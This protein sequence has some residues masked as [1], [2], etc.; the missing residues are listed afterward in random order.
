MRKKLLKNLCVFKKKNY[1]IYDYSI[2]FCLKNWDFFFFSKKRD[3]GLKFQ[4]LRKNLK[5]VSTIVVIIQNRDDLL[6]SDEET[7][8][9]IDEDSQKGQILKLGQNLLKSKSKQ[10]IE[11]TV[12]TIDSPTKTVIVSQ[13]TA[14]TTTIKT[15]SSNQQHLEKF[16]F[17]KKDKAYLSRLSSYV[18]KTLNLGS[19]FKPVKAETKVTNKMVFSRLTQAPPNEEIILKDEVRVESD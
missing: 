7:N 5:I 1:L 2:F 19:G 3:H 10:N 9:T 12:I 8:D 14:T 17:L 18:N 11:E 6:S 16:S 4:I 15:A 13:T